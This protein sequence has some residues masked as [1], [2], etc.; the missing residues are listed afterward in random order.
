MKNILYILLI[1]FAPLGTK[2]QDNYSINPFV[3]NCLDSGL[4]KKYHKYIDTN[5]IN[6]EFNK[7]TGTASFYSANLHGTNTAKGERYSNKKYTA[8]SNLFVLNSI[9]KVTSLKNGKSVLVRINDRMHPYMLKKGR[10]IDLSGVAA[11]KLAMSKHGDGLVKV[12]VEVVDKSVTNP[13][14]ED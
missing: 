6:I 9:V 2:A 11:K 3:E 8:A 4:I 14:N 1:F 5:R 12:V 7:V 13:K 10:V